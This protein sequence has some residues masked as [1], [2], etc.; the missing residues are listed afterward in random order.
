MSKIVVEMTAK[1][2]RLLAALRNVT[3]GTD[4]VA[5]GN[6]KINEEARQAAIAESRLVREAKKLGS[7]ALPAQEKYNRKVRDLKSALDKNKISQHEYNAAVRAAKK[8]FESAKQGMTNTFGPPS[9]KMMAGAAAGVAGINKAVRTLVSFATDAHEEIKGMADE[10]MNAHGAGKKLWQISETKE[11]YESL[12]AK[13][14]LAMATEGLS[15]EQAMQ[16]AFDLKSGRA[17][18]ALPTIARAN[19]FVDASTAGKFYTSMTGETGFGKFASPEQV[20]SGLVAGADTSAM[21]ADQT[22]Q[23]AGRAAKFYRGGSTPAEM[24]AIGS[25]IASPSDDPG[26]LA[27]SMKSLA[28]G[29]Q[30]YRAGKIEGA[31]P[32]KGAGKDLL[33]LFADFRKQDAAYRQF[34]MSNQEFA[35]AA[36][37]LEGGYATAV[38]NRGKIGQAFQS[39]KIFEAK[40]NLPVDLNRQQRHAVAEMQKTVALDRLAGKQLELETAKN[41]LTAVAGFTG[42]PIAVEK[43]WEKMLDKGATFAGASAATESANQRLVDQIRSQRPGLYKRQIQPYFSPMRAT[44]AYASVQDVSNQGRVDVPRQLSGQQEEALTA[45]MQELA[46]QGIT[47]DQGDKIIN[48]LDRLAG[49]ATGAGPEEDR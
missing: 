20:M 5:D 31:T 49:P 7:E 37:A 34:K 35:A 45:A 4:G 40:T 14:K 22:A 13:S 3:K 23:W 27:T 1:E 6:K 26:T 24:L 28:V 36:N 11:T 15:R 16:L 42:T 12:T 38:A 41:R 2:A 46:T 10:L 18:E 21:N 33:S 8:D 17:M 32:T 25:A 47:R 19:R 39:G 43:G 9:V 48:G 44:G 29:L 30:K